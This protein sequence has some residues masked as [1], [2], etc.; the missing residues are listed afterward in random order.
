MRTPE[1][2]ARSSVRLASAPELAGV[3]GGYVVNGPRRSARASYD[4]ALARRL[5]DVSAQLTSL[6]PDIG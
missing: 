6:P 2:G 1:Q 3:T 5:W 4:E